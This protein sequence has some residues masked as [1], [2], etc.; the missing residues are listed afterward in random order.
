MPTVRMWT[1]QEARALR[2][3]LRLSVRAFAEHL[4]VAVRTVSKWENLGQ[5]IQPRP[6]TQAI[7]DTALERADAAGQMRFQMLL[8]ETG[9]L[10][11][12][13]EPPGP[14][15]W[16]Y[17][18]WADDLERAVVL[19]SWQNFPAATTLINRRLT[20]FPAGRLDA[21]GQYL[22]ARSLVLLG[23]AQRDQGALTG[24]LSAHHSYRQ[25]LGVF[26]ELDIPRRVAQIELSLAVVT[27]MT[28]SLQD[29]ARRYQL[30][31][32]DERLSGRDRARSLLWVGTALSK[33]G[34]HDYAARVM[35]DAALQFEDLGEAY[36]WSVA[37]QKLALAYRGSGDLGQA[38]HFIDLA[39]TSG[40]S[41]TPLQRVR[42]STARAHILLTDRATCEDGL[43]LLDQTAELARRSGLA[44]QLHN[45]QAIRGGFETTGA[46]PG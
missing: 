15:L 1:G 23:D 30:L 40:T 17:E 5:A 46:R 22:R 25:A 20:L 37:Q 38:L 2:R 7:L 45:I 34:E 42:L 9:A 43:T 32:A 24:P 39:R 8:G 33:D 21:K 36:D 14:D 41:D 13:G 27:E 44:H 10:L 16:D 29:A 11:R 4:G 18:T 6:D 35:A 12:R 3:A 19:L 28:G 26:S 31:A